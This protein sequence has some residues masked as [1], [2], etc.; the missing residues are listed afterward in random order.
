[1]AL[2]ASMK[3]GSRSSAALNASTARPVSRSSS[4]RLSPSANHTRLARCASAWSSGWP[5]IVSSISAAFPGWR[6]SRYST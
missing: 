3:S 2:K 6:V 4:R 1:M 5:S